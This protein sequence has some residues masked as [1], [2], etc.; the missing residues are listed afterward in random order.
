MLHKGV[1]VFAGLDQFLSGVL[2]IFWTTL[3][4]TCTHTCMCMSFYFKTDT[5]CNSMCRNVACW[6]A[7]LAE[8]FGCVFVW[9][10]AFFKGS[11]RTS[12]Q[13]QWSWRPWSN[14]MDWI[15]RRTHLGRCNFQ[16]GRETNHCETCAA[17]AKHGWIMDDNGGYDVLLSRSN[18]CNY[19]STV[20]C[21]MFTCWSVRSSVHGRVNF[22]GKNQVC[23][24]TLPLAME[25]AEVAE[26]RR[27]SG[28]MFD[29]LTELSRI[30]IPPYSHY[31][32]LISFAMFATIFNWLFDTC[33]NC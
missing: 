33:F 8:M 11:G 12:T 23:E 27:W 22:N 18:I 6:A 26:A 15:W 7:W 28:L 21:K 19:E 13:S 29:E 20:T 25:S 30:D 2:V 10:C 3:D 32:V 14:F 31:N 24:V 17:S 4:N 5:Q 1:R 9:S 16:Q